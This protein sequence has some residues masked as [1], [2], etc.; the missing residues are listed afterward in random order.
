M[1][2]DLNRRI[3][4]FASEPPPTSK[5]TSSAL[6]A[7]YARHGR[8]AGAPSASGSA[9]LGAASGTSRRRVATTPERVLDA[10]GLADDYY[11][12]L[13]DW[14]C[15]NLVAIALEASVYIWNAETSEVSC[16]CSLAEDGQES[17][18]YI[19]SIRFS[20][21]GSYLALGNSSGSVQIYDLETGALIR[22]MAGHQSR[23]PTV[24]WFG[25]TLSSGARDGSIWNH[26]V[27]SREHKIGEMVGHRGEVCGLR[28]RPEQADSV[29]AGALGLLASGGNDNVVN[30]WD[31][32]MLNAPKMTKTN[33]TAAVK[34]LA[35]SP[36]QSSLLASGGGS[37]DKASQAVGLVKRV[38]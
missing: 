2:I 20:G 22:T 10:P 3:L 34:A 19:C 28:W 11:L 16:L 5:D 21:D 18:E 36:W 37:S 26:D 13:V 27:R 1:G 15:G 8:P 30:V 35:W 12:N 29:T 38:R 14:S 32:R 33:H 23:I 25:A 4:T 24:D 17:E 9:G 6:L 31:G 7:A